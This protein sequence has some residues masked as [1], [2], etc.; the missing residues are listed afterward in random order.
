[1]LADILRF[2]RVFD[3]IERDSA[4]PWTDAALAAG[5]FDQSHL[6]RD[7]RRFVGCTPTEFA[8]A[9]PGLASALVES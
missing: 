6:V 3:A 7:F 5:Y 1:M 4:R 2:R 8:A 9:R